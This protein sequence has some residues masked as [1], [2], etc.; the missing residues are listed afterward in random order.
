MTKIVSVC[1][2]PSSSAVQIR[3]YDMSDAAEDV[4][5]TATGVTERA[6]GLSK[7]C[8]HYTATLEPGHLYQIDWRD[9]ASPTK[10]ASEMLY[11]DIDLIALNTPE[12]HSG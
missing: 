6:V 5:W 1:N 2:M 8:Y 12:A 4:A 3:I 11:T 9:A 7:S 10:V